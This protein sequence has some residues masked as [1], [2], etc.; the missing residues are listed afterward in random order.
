MAKTSRKENKQQEHQ[1]QHELCNSPVLDHDDNNYLE[2]T[3]AI[4]TTTKSN[5]R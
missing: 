1:K 2:T 3:T 5:K 4:T